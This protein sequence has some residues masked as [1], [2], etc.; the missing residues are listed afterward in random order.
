MAA[1][2]RLN[3]PPLKQSDKI[4]A[5]ST[6]AALSLGSLIE[7]IKGAVQS[8][9]STMIAFFC[10]YTSRKWNERMIDSIQH[11]FLF[12]L[13]F[14]VFLTGIITPKTIDRIIS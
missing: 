10:C 7:S 8:V 14:P 5:R 1:V 4:T 6:Y 3:G 2:A 9:F 12:A 11:T 13:F